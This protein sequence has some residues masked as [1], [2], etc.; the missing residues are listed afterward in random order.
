[1]LCSLESRSQSD[2]HSVSFGLECVSQTHKRV[3]Q[4]VVG[5]I[6]SS[7]NTDNAN[8]NTERLVC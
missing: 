8:A 5:E 2:T 4:I 6:P 7:L 3:S 1:M